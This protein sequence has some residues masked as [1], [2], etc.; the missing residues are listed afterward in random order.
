MSDDLSG[1]KAKCDEL[2]AEVKTVKA[3][4]K[5]AEA[6]RDEA[7]EARSAALA[8]VERVTVTEPVAAVMSDLF[9]VAFRRV[10]PDLDEHFKFVRDDAGRIALRTKD[11][12]PVHLEAEGREAAFTLEDLRKAV[13]QT[14]GF[15]DVL[16]ATRASGGG[17]ASPSASPQPKAEPAPKPRVAGTLGL[18]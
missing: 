5:E 12:E 4:L 18:R 1:L 10:K 11:G 8:E 3:R 7:L 2:L 14:G 15:D 9:S 13:A 16:I 6:E 17:S